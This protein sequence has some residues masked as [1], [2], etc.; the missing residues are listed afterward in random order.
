MKLKRILKIALLIVS[1]AL[2]GFLVALMYT[3]FYIENARFE[4]SMLIPLFM[5]PTGILSIGYHFKTIKF[6]SLKSKATGFKDVVLWVGNTL[7]ATSQVLT[8]LYLSYS[9]YL[10]YQT[11]QNTE[12]YIAYMV[13]L[14]MFIFGLCLFLETYHLYKRI[15]KTEEDLF[16]G[17]IDDI[18]GIDQNQD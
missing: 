15:I 3:V 6:Y 5:I 9:L 16:K 10:L 12:V 7:F 14:L 18:T 11:N 2:T 8:A 1:I 17:S 13:C 4:Y